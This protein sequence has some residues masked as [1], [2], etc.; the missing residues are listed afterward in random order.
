M[1]VSYRQAGVDTEKA[2]VLLKKLRPFIENTYKKSQY[3][4]VSD[5]FGSFSGV[6]RP[7]NKFRKYDIAAATDGVGTKIELCTKFSYLEPLGYDLVAMCVNDLYCSGALPAFFLDYI[8]CGKLDENWY[9]P[10]IKSISKAC[11]KTGMV[12]LGGETAEHP[13]L[14]KVNEFDLAGFCVGFLSQKRHLPKLNKI[15]KNDL[16][17]ALPSSGLHSNGFS[18]VRMILARLEK[19]KPTEYK[20]L[21]NDRKWIKNHLLKATRIYHEIPLLLSKVKAHIKAI[22]HITGGGI[23]ENLPRVIP[24]NLSAVITEKNAFRLPIYDWLKKF[25]SEKEL[26]KTF[27]MG[28]GLL[29]ITDDHQKSLKKLKKYIPEAVNIG[30]LKDKKHLNENSVII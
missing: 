15:K 17:M 22:A 11:E 6:F 24:K 3:G 2:Q 1:P 27:N 4:L 5:S 30:Y 16:I 19:E 12:L 28:Y 7:K 9:T 25:S 10:I 20:N 8:A 13:K 18:L 14:M 29:M 21:T 26:F 23:C